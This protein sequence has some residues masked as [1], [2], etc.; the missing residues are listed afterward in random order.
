M[1]GYCQWAIP[2]TRWVQLVGGGAQCPKLS[3]SGFVID[4]IAWCSECSISDLCPE[5]PSKPPSPAI[6]THS[7]THS[8]IH[9]LQAN[10]WSSKTPYQ[11]KFL[12]DDKCSLVAKIWHVLNQ[13]RRRHHTVTLLYFINWN[14]L[15]RK[16]T[17][18]REKSIRVN[19]QITHFEVIIVACA[20]VIR[21][22]YKLKDDSGDWTKWKVQR[23]M[24][25]GGWVC[26]G[27]CVW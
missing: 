1:A 15:T 2:L 22:N 27:V 23:S 7:L 3:Q 24:P 19:K 26:W 9:S 4:W 16:R 20:K 17:K 12:Q 21:I 25:G 18:G 10:I 5:Q 11:N 8:L 13:K 6:I 14:L